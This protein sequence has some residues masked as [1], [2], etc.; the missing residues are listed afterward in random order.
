ML[1][2]SIFFMHDALKKGFSFGITSGV[3]TTL[4][5]IVGLHAG[6]HSR[7]VVLGGIITIAVADAFSDA[8]GIHITEEF[9]NTATNREIWIATI[10]TFI[11]K[12][13][14]ALSFVVPILLIENLFFAILSSVAWGVFLLSVVS[15]KISIE[16]K[17]PAWKVVGEHLLISI[18]VI[19]A[20]HAVGNWVGTF[21]S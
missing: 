18:I 10:S 21:F 1:C 19:A 16:K 5:L 13:L 11:F 3:I 8:F 15:I 17:I 7:V 9:Q 20:T 4:G 6:T 12:F 14:F 2:N